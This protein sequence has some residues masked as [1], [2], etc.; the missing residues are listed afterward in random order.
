MGQRDNNET[1]AGQPARAQFVY[2]TPAGMNVKKAWPAKGTPRQPRANHEPTTRQP[3]RAQVVYIIPARVKSKRL[4]RPTGLFY[5]TNAVMTAKK[6]VAGQWDTETTTRQPRNIHGTTGERTACL[7][8]SGGDDCKQ[9]PATGYFCSIPKRMIAERLGWLM[10]H[11][12]NRETTGR[13]LECAQF[14]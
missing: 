5:N 1:T 10:G 13:Q 8:H 4:G 2:S 6:S 7:Q 3:A 12:D 9:W 11:R 14:V